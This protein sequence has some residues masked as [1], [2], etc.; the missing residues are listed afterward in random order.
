MEEVPA[1]VHPGPI[2]PDVLSRQHEHRSG[3]IWSGDHEI[4]MLP[5]LSGNLVH[6]R[7]FSLLKDIDA[8]RTYSWGSC[9]FPV[10]LSRCCPWE[11]VP[12]RGARGVKR[13]THRQPG[14]GAEGRRS[15]VPP[16][17]DRHEH[18]DPGHIEVER[19]EG[20]RGGQPTID[21]FDSSNLD[22][23]SFSLGLTQHSQSLPSGSGILQMPFPP[24]F[25]ICPI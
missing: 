12:D 4:H 14:R 18:A 11:H 5:D 7:Y 15:P 8:I 6:V 25:R 17:P 3:L 2:V 22:I 20:S 16:F 9:T 1:H 23:S 21:P 19:G 13:G 24:R 10:Q